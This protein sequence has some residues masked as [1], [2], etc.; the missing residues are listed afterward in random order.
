MAGT[1]IEAW[2]KTA[3]T[4]NRAA[5]LELLQLLA[6]PHALTALK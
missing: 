3:V 1:A 2:R 6:S 4:R 5:R